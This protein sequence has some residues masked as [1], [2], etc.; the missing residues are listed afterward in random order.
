MCVSLCR[1]VL[2]Q[3][4]EGAPT[5]CN[6]ALCWHDR[7]QRATW[8][9]TI[10]DQP[11]HSNALTLITSNV[12]AVIFAHRV[13]P[14][15]LTHSSSPTPLNKS[16]Q[17][18]LP[19]LLIYSRLHFDHFSSLFPTDAV[20]CRADTWSEQLTEDELRSDGVHSVELK[21]KEP[22]ECHMHPKWIPH[23]VCIISSPNSWPTVQT[24]NKVHSD[25]RCILTQ[26]CWSH[27]H[28]GPESCSSLKNVKGNSLCSSKKG[29][30]TLRKCWLY[31]ASFLPSVH[32]PY[33]AE[34]K[35]TL[36][37]QGKHRCR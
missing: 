6:L 23:V 8:K 14:L 37:W 19:P 2:T 27:L 7:I 21:P 15:G 10:T 3:H 34:V 28:R 32:Q 31:L 4:H 25:P 12:R 18:C 26:V 24:G 33:L 17:L 16:Q 36:G 22:V 13:F 9:Q 11:K 5:L 30:K 35:N 20:P 1:V 29:S